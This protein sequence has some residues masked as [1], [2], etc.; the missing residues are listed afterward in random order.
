MADPL[1]W[2]RSVDA[3]GKAVA[4]WLD[5]LERSDFTRVFLVGCGTSFYAA[6]VGKYV[7]EHIACLPA[8]AIQAFEFAT[9]ANPELL[10]SQ[11]LV[12]GISATGK[13][14]AARDALRHAQEAGSATVAVTADIDSDVAQAAEVVVPIG[15]D[16]N[17]G[18]KTRTYVQSLIALYVLAL[19][20]GEAGG[21]VDADLAGYWRRQIDL[22]A[23][24]SR[25][26][27][28][29]QQG[30]IEELAKLYAQAPNVFVLGTGP[31]AGTAEEASLKVI[32]MAK[33]FSDACPLEEFLHGR[34][35]EVDGQTPMLFVAPQGRASDRVLDFLTVT[36][37]IGVPS[38]VLTDRITPGIE[39]LATH[40][41]HV[42]VALDEFATPL[43]YILPLYLFGYHVALE[44]GYDPGSRR[45]PD[46]VPQD[47]R[48]GAA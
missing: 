30:Q 26:F 46:I 20:L 25:R 27:L 24:G 6:Q 1:T 37:L 4:Q 40:V 32:E 34:L 43:L 42:P 31:N 33:M 12:V 45:Y 48:Y 35:R 44:R 29:R 22:A 19:R 10:S 38:V 16:I 21:Q 11:T 14:T 7:L 13:T 5:R 47:V 9:Y 36:D 8:E 17:V 28:D 23:E 15:G 41:V 39:R 18:V 2:Q 3:T